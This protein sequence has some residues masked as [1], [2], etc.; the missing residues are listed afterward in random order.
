M[1]NTPTLFILGAGASKPYGYPTGA[2]LRSD[3]INNFPADF[4]SLYG[5]KPPNMSLNADIARERVEY[6]VK[7]FDDSSLTSIDKYLSINTKDSYIGKIAITLSILKSE[8]DSCF[9]ERIEDSNED[10]YQYIYNR[11]TA[12]LKMPEDHKHFFNNQ[13]AFITFNYDRSLEYY[14]Y[15]SFYHSFRQE[16]TQIGNNI[17]DYVPFEI[18]H[19]YGTVGTLSLS[20]WYNNRQDYRRKFEFFNLVEARSKG[21]WVIG[22]E[23]SGESIADQIKKLLPKYKRIFFLG[24]GYAKENLDAID[25]AKNISDKTRVYGTASG[26]TKKEIKEI[27]GYFPII[28]GETYYLQ[29]TEESIDT[30]FR[31]TIKNINCRELLREYL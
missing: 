16:C 29:D 30:T 24:F 10:W 12:D 22:E 25:F 9:N 14:L 6:F 23:I 31:P 20:D 8:R 26:M 27:S 18:I 28:P 7:N 15:N 3:I 2:K 13:V 4:L 21:I 11:M 1:I 17:R 19:V 5:T